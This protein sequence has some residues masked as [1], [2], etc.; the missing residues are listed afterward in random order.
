MEIVLQILMGVGLVAVTILIS[1][2]AH[3]VSTLARGGATNP[4]LSGAESVLSV[5]VSII[6]IS[7]SIIAVCLLVVLMFVAFRVLCQYKNKRNNN[8]AS[9]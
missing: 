2:R 6:A 4:V 3:G 7:I 8:R 5:L 1:N 9:G